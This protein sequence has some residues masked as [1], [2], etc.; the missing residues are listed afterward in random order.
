[1]PAPLRRWAPLAIAA[2]A[3]C[4]LVL[5]AVPSV[6]QIRW[7]TVAMLVVSGVMIVA[8]H[9]LARPLSRSRSRDRGAGG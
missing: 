1:V 7:V 3:A 4:N 9:L 6:R 2:V 5:L 8:L